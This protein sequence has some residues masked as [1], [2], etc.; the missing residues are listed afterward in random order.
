MNIG[1]IH[2]GKV[3]V[4]HRVALTPQHCQQILTQYPAVNLFLQPSPV[5]S[6]EQE[7]YEKVG[8]QVQDNLDNCEVLFG[9]KEVPIPSLLEGKTYFFFSHT[10]KKQPYNKTLLQT[11][12]KKNV[13]LIDYECLTNEQGNRIVAFGRYAG[14]VGAYNGIL[15]Y[16]KRFQSFNLKPAHQCFDMNEMWSEFSNVK[17]PNVKI[18][19]TGAGRVSQGAMEVLDGMN[20]KKVSPSDFLI[21]TFDEAVYT[22]LDTEDYVK[23]QKGKDLGITHF[24]ENAT[25]Y[26]TAFVPY[27]KQADILI[28]GAYWDPKAPVLFTKEDMRASDFQIKVIADITCD[29]EGSVPSTLKATTIDQPHFDYNPTTEQEEVA[30]SD[31]KNVTVM[32]VDNLPCELP[33]DAST[34]FGDQLLANVFAELLQEQQPIL[35]R[36][37]ITKQGN[38]TERYNY[39]SDYVAE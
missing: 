18:V 22:Q 26:T 35:N 4:D 28:A 12:L 19:L 5:R 20:I 36:A 37:M 1:I 30:F 27:T 24:Y 31:E 14:I 11:I 34:S 25:E 3:P 10:I 7:E 32:S 9:V 6:F 23:H 8:V 2:E 29:I 39:L 33:R 16:G 13:N 17:L 15:T 38:L 21:Q